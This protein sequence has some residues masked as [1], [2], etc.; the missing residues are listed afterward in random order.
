MTRESSPTLFYSFNA[1][2]LPPR[3]IARQFV[4]SDHYDRLTNPMHSLI[5]G[6][7]GSG[8]T[9]LLKML[10]PEALGAWQAPAAESY[11]DKVAYSGVFIATDRLWEAQLRAMSQAGIED[12]A[13]FLIDAIFCTH[14]LRS[15]VSSMHSRAQHEDSHRRVHLSPRSEADFVRA[16]AP[17]WGVAPPIPTLLALKHSLTAR[18]TE[19]SAITRTDTLLTAADRRRRLT[20]IPQLA[21]GFIEAVSQGV[22]VFNDLTGD[23]HARWALLFDELE[24]APEWIV[25]GLLNA[26]RSVDERLLFKLSISPFTSVLPE[27]YEPD[28]PS[29]GHD[30]E[31]LDLWYAQKEA[32]YAFTKALY[33]S[34][35]A[36]HGL[37]LSRSE[38]DVFGWS[39]FATHPSEFANVATAY[40]QGSRRQ[41]AFARLAAKDASFADYLNRKSIEP[42]RLHEIP[43]DRRAAEVRKITPLVLLRDS[44]LSTSGSV[45]RLRSRKTPDLFFGA[46]T[47]FAMTEG[48]PRWL[49]GLIG[50][51]LADLDS[52]EGTVGKQKQSRYVEQATNRFRSLLRTIPCADSS[53]AKRRQ[54]VLQLLDGVG[55][56]IH[57]RC[58]VD[59]FNPDP[60]GSFT[61]DSNSD[62]SVLEALGQALNAGAIVYVPDQPGDTL[63]RSMRGKRF[64]LC[65]LL[66]PHYKI[67]IRLGRAISLGRI[68]NGSMLDDDERLFGSS[69]DANA[70]E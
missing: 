62:P 21:I 17:T 20:E 39:D 7:R 69:E 30:Y 42:N 15:L 6:P 51:L 8:K 33:R 14:V 22:E 67:P 40:N 3:D 29:A 53:G 19:L 49:V 36:R 37:D 63:L 18:L 45:N 44:H 11:R 41:K 9:T 52:P 32:G 24:L 35:A 27:T 38:T 66:A 58:V 4:V 46:Q 59:P 1:R 28:A 12:D 57:K 2:T 34:L 60:A 54:S 55:D 25:K 10:H 61:V 64:R 43:S 65:Y 70:H 68:L 50:R 5:V 56:Y 16:V 26:P 31:Q 13:R 48:N 23:S 47:L